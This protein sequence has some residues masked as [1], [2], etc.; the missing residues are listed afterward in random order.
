MTGRFLG[1]RGD[2]VKT[3]CSHT[4]KCFFPDKLTLAGFVTWYGC[5]LGARPQLLLWDGYKEE[6][7][8]EAMTLESRS[9]QLCLSLSS[10]KILLFYHV[11]KHGG[12]ADY[13]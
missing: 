1:L 9:P 4:F 3:S 6:M 2:K 10:S 5:V 11:S 12:L 13:E 8:L 7:G